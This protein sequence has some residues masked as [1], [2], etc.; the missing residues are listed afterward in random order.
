MQIDIEYRPLSDLLS[1][2][3]SDKVPSLKASHGCNPDENQHDTVHELSISP[4]QVLVGLESFRPAEQYG[5]PDCVYDFCFK[6]LDIKTGER[7][8]CCCGHA[9]CHMCACASK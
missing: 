3:H 8:T 7:V 4:S 9:L 2:D 5:M 6:V 1:S